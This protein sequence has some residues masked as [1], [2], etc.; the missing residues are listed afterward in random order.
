MAASALRNPN[1]KNLPD[2]ENWWKLGTDLCSNF[3]SKW[4]AGQIVL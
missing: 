4:R 3:C 1:Q 2:Q